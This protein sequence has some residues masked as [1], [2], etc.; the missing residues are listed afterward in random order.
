M[1]FTLDSVVDAVKVSVDEMHGLNKPR[2]CIGG[3][4]RPLTLRAAPDQVKLDSPV[5][6]ALRCNVIDL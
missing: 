1:S 3:Q 5:A 4:V 6:D 2:I